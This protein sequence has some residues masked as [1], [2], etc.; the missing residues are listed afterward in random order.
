MKFKALISVTFILTLIGCAPNPELTE[1]SPV[2]SQT[3]SISSTSTPIKGL[4]TPD[5]IDI[6]TPTVSVGSSLERCLSIDTNKSL[7]LN[8]HGYLILN[9]SVDA[10]RGSEYKINLETNEIMEISKP[11]EGILDISISPDGKWIAY[12]SYIPS[13][14]SDSLVIVDSLGK[15]V[16][17]IPW[18]TEWL[19]LSSW[20]DTNSL[21]ISMKNE[22]SL[23]T[24]T[25]DQFRKFLVFNPFTNEHIILEPDLPEI[26]VAPGFTGLIGEG[27][28]PDLDHVVYLQGDRAFIEPLHYMLWDIKQKR[29]LA[30]FE[31]V[32]QPTAFPTWS[33]DGSKFAL[34]A[35]I[36]EDIYQTW[37]AYELYTVNRD[38]QITQL[39]QLNNYYPWVYIENYSW[40]P[41]G[42]YIAFWF[43]WWSGEKPD[44]ELSGKRY[45]AVVDAENNDLTYLC[46]QGRPGDNGRVESP[47]WSPDGKQLSVESLSS[48]GN[49][50]VILIDLAQQI[51]APIAEDMT[52][53]GW[54]IA[55]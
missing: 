3:P 18:E 1:V 24:S 28:H 26:F 12:E 22:S 2:N 53:I 42:K 38:G 14:K 46:I 51:A 50:Q 27:F 13:T 34:A 6:I 52:P 29:S 4:G 7:D 40:S 10:N 20:L 39:T 31:V 30:D 23:E 8:F 25:A 32:L 19:F 43:S 41:N 48:E 5:L 21:L 9:G 17:N 37:P 11:G 16:E 35:S 44:G 47:V 36:K 55:P 45:L 49:S 15:Q 54:M 33:S